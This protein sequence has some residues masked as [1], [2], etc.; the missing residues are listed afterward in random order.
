MIDETFGPGEIRDHLVRGQISAQRP[1]LVADEAPDDVY[2]CKAGCQR[3][4]PSECQHSG[5]T[6]ADGPPSASVFRA[7]GHLA[8]W[9]RQGPRMI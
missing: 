6:E 1:S 5:R 3:R 7:T 9:P 8:Q 4:T 2:L